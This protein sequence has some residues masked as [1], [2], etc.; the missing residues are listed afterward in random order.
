M[1]GVK[2]MLPD[3]QGTHSPVAGSHVVPKL[4]LQSVV[5]STL[6]PRHQPTMVGVTQ[7]LAVV[8]GTHSPVAGSHEVPNMAEQLKVTGSAAVPSELQ[9]AMVSALWQKAAPGVQK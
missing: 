2:Q 3:V 7:M 4:A 8:Q 1:V 6:P 5:D 9:V